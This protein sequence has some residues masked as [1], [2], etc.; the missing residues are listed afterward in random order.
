[1]NACRLTQMSQE[2]LCNEV[3]SHQ[4]I[5]ADNT[6]QR[7]IIDTMKMH[8]CP[9]LKVNRL[10]PVTAL[11]HVALGEP[12]GTTAEINTRIFNGCGW[13]GFFKRV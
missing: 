3:E 2:Y 5:R 12:S 10:L 8:I 13:D 4:I 9:K 6:A 7:L 1:M 11:K